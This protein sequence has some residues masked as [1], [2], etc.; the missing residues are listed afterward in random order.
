MVNWKAVLVVAAALGA[1]AIGATRTLAG[2]P[3]P[4]AADPGLRWDREGYAALADAA[5]DAKA[6]GRRLLLGLSGSPT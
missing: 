1:T 2:D 3:T 5:D 6:A 4:E